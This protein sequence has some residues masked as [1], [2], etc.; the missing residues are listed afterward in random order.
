[1]GGL[2]VWYVDKLSVLAIKLFSVPYHS[3]TYYIVVIENNHEMGSHLWILATLSESR[4]CLEFLYDAL[5]DQF[6]SQLFSSSRSVAVIA[7]LSVLWLSYYSVLRFISM[8]FYFLALQHPPCTLL[9]NYYLLVFAIERCT[10]P[11]PSQYFL[12]Y[13]WRALCLFNHAVTSTRH[14]SILR[15]FCSFLLMSVLKPVKL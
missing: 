10:I 7:L 8:Y 5:E 1:M 2:F 3:K 15:S 9:F 13:Y 12:L 14:I 11:L 4:S 6:L